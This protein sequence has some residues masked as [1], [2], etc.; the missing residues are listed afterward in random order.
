M[1]IEVWSDVVCPYCY[2][3]LAQLES[4]LEKF[5]HAEEVTVVPRAFEL[6]PRMSRSGD[7]SARELVATK[8]GLSFDQVD[9]NHR[10]LGDSVA[11]F[12]LEWNVDDARPTNTFDAHRLIALARR[13]NQALEA[14]KRLHLAYFANGDLVS[15]ID[16]LVA[17]GT[18]LNLPDVE[19]LRDPTIG[20]AEVRGDEERAH[21]LGLRGVPAFL[22]NE[23]YVVSGAQGAD[24]LLGALQQVYELSVA[25]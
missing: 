16:T 25:S 9:L 14:T 4:A 11:E 1:L 3:G 7:L 10:R 5:E 13:T 24:G 21:S 18:E 17:L 19:L 6:D 15:D 20:A 8:Y 12:G 23:R 2:L 22:F